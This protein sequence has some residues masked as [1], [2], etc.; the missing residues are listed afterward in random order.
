MKEIKTGAGTAEAENSIVGSAEVSGKEKTAK[1]KNIRKTENIVGILYGAVGIATYAFSV[2]KILANGQLIGSLQW[3]TYMILIVGILMLYLSLSPRETIV[4]KLRRKK[5]TLHLSRI[6][7]LIQFWAMVLLSTMGILDESGGQYNIGMMIISIF[8]G[9]RYG[10]LNRRGSIIIVIFYAA[11]TEYS[12]WATGELVRAPFIILYLLFFFGISY[13]LYREALNR[14]FA[15]VNQYRDRLITMEE[16]LSKYEQETIDISSIS[17][18]PRE[19]E[20]LE[21][22]CRTRASN[23]DLAKGL[24]ITQ[25]TVKTHLSNIFDKA[26]TDDRHQLIDLFRGNFG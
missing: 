9:L 8:L 25:Q 16:K 23:K 17:F 15:I 4:I 22:L 21:T 12:A 24:G 11:I 5:A 13:L 2:V 10:I 18:T 20:V 1:R 6:N 3:W 14:H 19:L 7:R 26:G